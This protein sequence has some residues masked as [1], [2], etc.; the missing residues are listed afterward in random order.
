MEKIKRNQRYFIEINILLLSLLSM[1]TESFWFGGLLRLVS[2]MFYF[3][4]E[5]VTL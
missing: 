5:R 1:M 2:Y 3:F 4:Y